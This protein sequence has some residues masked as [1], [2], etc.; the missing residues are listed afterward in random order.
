MS[1]ILAIEANRLNPQTG[2][3]SVEGKAASSMNALKTGIYAESSIIRGE[4]AGDLRQLTSEYYE[5][6]APATPEERLLVDTLVHDEWLL[7]RFR[8]IDA[9][10]FEYQFKNYVHPDP[11]TDPGRAFSNVSNTFARLQR[12]ISETERSYLRVLKELQHLRATRT[13]LPQAV[14]PAHIQPIAPPVKPLG[15]VPQPA[16]EAVP[17]PL[18]QPSPAPVPVPSGRRRIAM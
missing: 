17:S 9:A 12:R 5:R 11:A 2:P 15:F 18:P 3:R 4:N 6:F 10:L 16:P 1:T 13:D 8:R 14:D 7:R